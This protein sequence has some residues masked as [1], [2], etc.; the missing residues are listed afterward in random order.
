M[1]KITFNQ[2]LLLIITV[3]VF[4]ILLV[5]SWPYTKKAYDQYKY[6]KEQELIKEVAKEQYNKS[7]E[8]ANK[9]E[10]TL[11]LYNS[12]LKE[13]AINGVLTMSETT[14]M[15]VPGVIAS[16]LG[17]VWIVDCSEI[18]NVMS[19]KVEYYDWCQESFTT[20]DQ[21]AEDDM[22]WFLKGFDIDEDWLNE[23]HHPECYLDH[24][25]VTTEKIIEKINSFKP[26]CESAIV[27]TNSWIKSLENETVTYS[28]LIT[29]TQDAIKDTERNLRNSDAFIFNN[30]VY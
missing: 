29:A 1:K 20:R 13:P 11:A 28:S 7:L 5:V 14:K 3:L 4:G 12:V 27:K 16:T 8:E 18:N 30:K 15:I 21:L 25:P 26:Q 17:S 2:I 19:N 24:K 9:Y 23:Y 10:E 6:N 22:D